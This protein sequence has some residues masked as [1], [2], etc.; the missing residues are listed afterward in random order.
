MISPIIK[1]KLI[2]NRNLCAALGS[3]RD[4]ENNVFTLTVVHCDNE[5][6]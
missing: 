5:F 4:V 2:V 1:K 3:Y 6:I